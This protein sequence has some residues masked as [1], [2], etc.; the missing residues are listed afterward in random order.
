M[1]VELKGVREL[2]RRLDSTPAAVRDACGK[3]LY[4]FGEKIMSESKDRYVPV[5]TG[6][7]KR[8]G[9]VDRPEISGDNVSVKLSYGGAAQAYALVQHERTDFH[10][11]HGQAKYLET[12]V[13][14]HGTQAGVNQFLVPEIR[15]ELERAAS[16]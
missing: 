9:R 12:P 13:K 4:R 8:S 5:D 11:P 7:L 14:I 15:R 6:T 1:T 10:H 2:I 3:G 16:R